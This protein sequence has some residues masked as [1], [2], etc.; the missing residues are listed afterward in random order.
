M[1]SLCGGGG[2]GEPTRAVAANSPE[3]NAEYPSNMMTNTK[4][5]WYNFIPKNLM[6]QFRYG[7]RF[8]LRLDAPSYNPLQ[9]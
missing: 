4:Y 7:W 6:E 9:A 2:P 8:N 3:S 5:T 1:S